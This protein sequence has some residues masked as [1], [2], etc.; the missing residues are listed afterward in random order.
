MEAKIILQAL[1]ISVFAFG[2]FYL[3]ASFVEADI[4]FSDWPQQTRS[5]VGIMGGVV[6]MFCGVM[7]LF[8][9]RS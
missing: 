8:Y 5:L 4:N 2:V 3:L 1:L 6:S 7:Y 9:P